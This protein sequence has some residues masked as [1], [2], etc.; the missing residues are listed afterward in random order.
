MR[1][2]YVCLIIIP[3]VSNV[4]WAKRSLTLTFP[5]IESSLLIKQCHLDLAMYARKF[6]DEV[7]T[8]PDVIVCGL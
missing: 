7:L 1:V 5:S 6:T 8:N 3:Q 2:I 4:R